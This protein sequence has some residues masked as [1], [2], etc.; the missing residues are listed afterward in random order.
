MKFIIKSSL[1][2]VFILFTSGIFAR[3]ADSVNPLPE[4]GEQII[5]TLLTKDTLSL[6]SQL[7]PDENLNDIFSEKMRSWNNR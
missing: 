6:E 5:D 7:F 2:C 3:Q 1:I 4:E